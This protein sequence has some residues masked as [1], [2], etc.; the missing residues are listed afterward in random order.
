MVANLGMITQFS[1]L[2][3][4]EHA[5]AQEWDGKMHRPI[6]TQGYHDIPKYFDFSVFSTATSQNQLELCKTRS[7]DIIYC[8]NVEEFQVLF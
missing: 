6:S 5:S 3:L 4:A 7:N 8:E 2:V 1:Y